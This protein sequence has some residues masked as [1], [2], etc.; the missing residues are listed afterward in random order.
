MNK[1]LIAIISLISVVNPSTIL[2]KSTTTEEKTFQSP[3][4][5]V[6]YFQGQNGETTKLMYNREGETFKYILRGQ[7]LKPQTPYTLVY[8]PEDKYN[9][10]CLGTGTPDKNGNLNIKTSIN[11]GSIPF[12]YDPNG[13]LENGGG[14]LM[15]VQNYQIF[16][17]QHYIDL[18]Y[19]T[20]YL[21]TDSLINYT[22]I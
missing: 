16:C 21:T 1:L 9:I 14:K 15:L 4:K 11:I 3:I 13:N 2:N 22:K 19:I 10:S 8:Y 7:N 20:N 18:S 6:I 12:A 17:N 5:D